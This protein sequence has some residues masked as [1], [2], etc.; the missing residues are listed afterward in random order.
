MEALP[1]VA[2]NGILINPSH[3]KENQMLEITLR[4][5]E[6]KIFVSSLVYWFDPI[7]ESWFRK[8]DSDTPMILLVAYM[9]ALADSKAMDKG[10]SKLNSFA[11]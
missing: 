10:G 1:K 8:G 11:D 6:M 3:T 9:N 5:S 2:Q 7:T 4:A